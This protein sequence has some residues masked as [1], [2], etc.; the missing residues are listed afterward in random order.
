M[1]PE[2]YS[3]DCYELEPLISSDALEKLANSKVKPK[4]IHGILILVALHTTSLSWDLGVAIGRATT[5]V[6]HAAAEVSKAC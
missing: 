2:L 3:L 4:I 5:F 6:K 1:I